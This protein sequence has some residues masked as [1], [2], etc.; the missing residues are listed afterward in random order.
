[1]R[2]SRK[3]RSE[4]RALT[5]KPPRSTSADT[6]RRWFRL[7]SSRQ[8]SRPAVIIGT[9]SRECLEST[10]SWR[11]QPM[12]TEPEITTVSSDE[13]DRDP[14]AFLTQTIPGRIIQVL[15]PSGS[16]TVLMSAQD[17]ESYKAAN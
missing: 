5:L 10:R 2:S 13:F 17:F 14:E 12:A 1:M 3:L 4:R 11:S 9:I 16:A 15:L 8:L 7:G 6:L